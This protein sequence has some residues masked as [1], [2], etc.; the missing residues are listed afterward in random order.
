L[1]SS[2]YQAPMT[3]PER[4]GADSERRA[5]KAPD[6]TVYEVKQ[7]PRKT[8][9]WRKLADATSNP[10]GS[11]EFRMPEDVEP[12]ALIHIRAKVTT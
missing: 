6:H 12:G 5:I 11:I 9:V 1:K 7:T 3:E 4:M 2:A 10:D 8:M